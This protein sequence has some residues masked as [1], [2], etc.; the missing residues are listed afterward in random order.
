MA[1]DCPFG[2]ALGIAGAV[3]FGGFIING[4]WPFSSGVDN[5]DWNMLAATVFDGDKPV[6]SRLCVV[7]KSDYQ[8]I[9]TWDAM[10]MGA[11]GSKDVAA[12]E[13]FVP[14]RRAPPKGCCPT[15]APVGLS[16]M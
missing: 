2:P 3:T 13:I 9:D 15:T 12:N 7:P 4:R 10:G 11:T 14:D 6:D 8:I 5:S 16:L 1:S